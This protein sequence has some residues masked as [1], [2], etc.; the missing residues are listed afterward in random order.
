MALWLQDMYVQLGLSTKAAKLLDRVQGQDSPEKLKVLMDKNVDD[1]CNVVR[2]P[3][4]KNANGMPGRGQQVS[5][6]AL[7]NLKLAVFLFHH[8]WRCTSDWEIMGENEDTVCLMTGQRN[9]KTSIMTPMCCQKLIPYGRDDGC[10]RRITQIMS[11]CHEGI[12]SVH[13]KKDH[14]SA[15]LW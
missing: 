6:I 11:R 9:S 12:F 8:S 3:G 5:V 14:N 7:E 10:H 13:Y 2:R 4:G 15:D 1:I